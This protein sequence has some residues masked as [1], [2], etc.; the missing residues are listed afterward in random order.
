[1][2][3]Y[4]LGLRPDCAAASTIHSGCLQANKGKGARQ[5]GAGAAESL[6]GG[7]LWVAAAGW[8][9]GRALGAVWRLC[10]GLSRV[11]GLTERLM[12]AQDHGCVVLSPVQILHFVS[13]CLRIAGRGSWD[14]FDRPKKMR[15][16]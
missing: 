4:A 3:L 7:R 6:G 13:Y 15:K 14:S 9:C 2:R 10:C 8:A 1:M 16:Q 12:A 5:W 11:Q